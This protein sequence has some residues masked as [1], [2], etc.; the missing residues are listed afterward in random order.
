MSKKKVLPVSYTHLDVYKRQVCNDAPFKAL[1][2][3]VKEDKETGKTVLL[4]DTEFKIKNVETGEYVG[5]WVWFPIP[6]FVD[7]FT[8][9][10]SGTVTTPNTLDVG[11]YELVEIKAQMCI[12]D[13][14]YGI[15]S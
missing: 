11:T 13:R 12:R 7:T 2:Q 6:H 3:A 8:T 1:I 9:D 14:V 4:P 5:Q 15:P 10:E